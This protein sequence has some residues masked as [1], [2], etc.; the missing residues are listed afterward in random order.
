MRAN[1]LDIIRTQCKLRTT[2][3]G[4]RVYVEGTQLTAKELNKI[5]EPPPRT[6]ESI[7]S[8]AQKTIGAK[9]FGI[10][11]N[12]GENLNNELAKRMAYKISPLLKKQGPRFW[13]L[14]LLF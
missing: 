13:V 4:F 7:T 9:K 10:I 14:I 11:I 6:T 3:Y 1:I 5:Y 12:R 8:W 2:L